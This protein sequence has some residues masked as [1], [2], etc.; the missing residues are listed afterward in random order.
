[1]MDN[2]MMKEKE[3]TMMEKDDTMMKME[4]MDSPLKQMKSGV[5][6]SD[7]TCKEGLE[8]IFKVADGSAKCVS[9]NTASKLVARGWATQ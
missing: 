5:V 3:S 1:M 7:V 2:K 8:L 4:H 6:V 9:S